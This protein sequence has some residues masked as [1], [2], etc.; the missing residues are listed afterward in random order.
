VLFVAGLAV[1]QSSRLQMSMWKT[2]T[3]RV[4]EMK[5]LWSG[6][7]RRPQMIR[8]KVTLGPQLLARVSQH[9]YQIHV[10]CLE[11]EVWRHWVLRHDCCASL[12]NSWLR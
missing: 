7:S 6:E 5:S 1:A 11:A 4:Y 10:C 8:S 3:E 2:M 9:L 12:L